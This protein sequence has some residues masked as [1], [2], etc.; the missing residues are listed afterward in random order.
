MPWLR[1]VAP[2]QT[3]KIIKEIYEG[4]C[5]FNA[6]P[7]SLVVRITKQ[8]FYSPSIHREVAKVIQDCKKCK[9][10]SAIR[11]TGT[12]GAKAA[13]STS[14]FSHCGIH[15]IEPLPMAPEGLNFL[16]IAVEHST[17]WVKAKPLTI[18]NERQVE[19]F[20]WEYVVCTRI[21][22]SKEEKHF[23]EGMFTDLSK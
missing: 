23:K 20:I 14:P 18:I 15:I 21:I 7:H 6:E 22:S 19:K 10:E 2:P 11:E 12:S 16:A 5:G 3:D 1:C 13:G 9:E 4:S 8:D 17:K